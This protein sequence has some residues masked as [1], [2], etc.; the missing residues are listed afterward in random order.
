[1]MHEKSIAQRA[2]ELAHDARYRSIEDIRRRLAEDNYDGVYAHISGPTITR[3]L[4]QAIMAST[5][6]VIV[7]PEDE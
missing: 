2:F 6:S 1:M 4:R 5:D 3:Q 7:D